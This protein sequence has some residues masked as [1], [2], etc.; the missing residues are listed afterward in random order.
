MTT[1]KRLEAAL[2]SPNPAVALRGVVAEL[3]SEGLRKHPRVVRLSR[4]RISS[5]CCERRRQIRLLL[6]GVG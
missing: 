4:N 2:D 5:Q 1:A 3:A 6:V